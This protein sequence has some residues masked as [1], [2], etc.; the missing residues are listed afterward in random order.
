MA[1]LLGD[2]HLK[3]LGQYHCSLYTMRLVFNAEAAVLATSLQSSGFKKERAHI[4]HPWHMS[5]TALD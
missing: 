4:T 3:I 2:P 5:C 1:H